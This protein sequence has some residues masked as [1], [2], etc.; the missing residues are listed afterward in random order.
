LIA[1]LIDHA[2]Q[3]VDSS[4]DRKPNR[5][6]TVRRT[7]FGTVIAFALCWYLFGDTLAEAVLGIGLFIVWATLYFNEKGNN[8][9]TRTKASVKVDGLDD[10]AIK[11]IIE[12]LDFKFGQV[13]DIRDVLY[14][15]LRLPKRNVQSE[16]SAEYRALVAEEKA[17]LHR[18]WR[19]FVDAL[20]NYD[21]PL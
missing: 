7:I 19:D 21:E 20:L 2:N 10:P 14:A 12:K 8:S 17:K 1:H 11:R 6:A 4:L 3:L 15:L 5:E 18:Q 16:L 9:A 13:P